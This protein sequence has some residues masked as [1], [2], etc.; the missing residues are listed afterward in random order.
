MFNF[1]GEKYQFCSEWNAFF[2][3]EQSKEYFQVLEAKLQKEIHHKQIFPPI[4]SLF[5]IFESC[6]FSKIKVVILGQDPYHKLGQAH[7]MAF[8]VKDPTPIPPSLKNIFKEI[9]KD[10]P[11]PISG[12]LSQWAKQGVFL[13]NTTLT[14]EEKKPNS[15]KSIGWQTF[16]DAV[17]K[18]ISTKNHVV[19]ILWGSHAINKEKLINKK[20]NF[21]LTGP[22]PSPLSAYR[23]FFGSDHFNK[24]NAYL[25][26]NNI[27]LI[28]WKFTPV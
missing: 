8:S 10:S 1:L 24:A 7:G 27:R 18:K 14:V 22:H 12:D 28:N 26:Q 13:L 21:I 17:I 4:K 5:S 19:F 9:Y 20:N 3:Q 23:G 2:K 6:P 25:K 16:T 11:Q 15:H